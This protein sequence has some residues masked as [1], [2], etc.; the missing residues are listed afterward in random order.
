VTPPH[1]DT[2][3]NIGLALKAFQKTLELDSSYVL[4]YQHILDALL[5]CTNSN[6]W[7]C[8]GD[9][10]V[11][12][13]PDALSRRFGAATL[14]RLR[15][16]ARTEQVATARGWVAAVP[17]TPRARLALVQVLYDQQR[18]DDAAAELDALSR[19]GWIAQAGAW[20]ALV[21]FQRGRPGAGAAALD[22]ALATAPDTFELLV[23][24][25]NFGTPM[26]LLAGGGGRVAAGFAV[27][28]SVFGKLPVDSASGPGGLLMSAAELRRLTDGY[29]WSEAGLPAAAQVEADLQRMVERRTAR[30]STQL[31]R[32]V[33]SFGATSVAAYLA[34]RDTTVLAK[35]L[36]LVDTANSATWRVADA[37]LALARGDTAGARIGVD[38]HY[39]RPADVE[40]T[41]EQGVVR[42]YAWGDL[43]TRLGEAR[44]ALEAYGRLDSADQRVQHPGFVVRSW[45]ER[46]ALYQQLGQAPEAIEQYQRFIDAWKDADPELQPMVDRARA[47]VA[48]LKGEVQ[49]TRR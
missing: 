40:F 15:D 20:K 48:A 5:G 27:A 24:Q 3:G 4:A 35:F 18:Y 13:M 17:G 14:Q 23:G 32:L 47:A 2:L 11:Y 36:A 46:G 34:S 39:R 30:D 44:L 28:R 49:P 16:Q 8:T 9:S 29:L 19:L 45:A 38:R 6:V 33:T 37:Q 26:A 1:S 22:S 25:Q 43:L 21:E 31:R 41:G 7:V 12:G 42:T 10:A